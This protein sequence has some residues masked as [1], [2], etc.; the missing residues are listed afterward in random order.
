MMYDVGQ[1]MLNLKK[2]TKYSITEINK[3]IRILDK[4]EVEIDISPPMRCSK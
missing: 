2:E 4:C 1:F 3:I